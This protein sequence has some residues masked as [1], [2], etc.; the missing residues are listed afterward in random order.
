MESNCNS[1]NLFSVTA[2]NY[3]FTESAFLASSNLVAPTIIQ[4][5]VTANDRVER[6]AQIWSVDDGINSAVDLLKSDLSRNGNTSSWTQDLLTAK[7]NEL[8]IVNGKVQLDIAHSLAALGYTSVKQLT[9]GQVITDSFTYAVKDDDTGRLAWTTVT[10]SL[11]GEGMAANTVA[12]ISGTVS[13]SVSEDG[14]STNGGTVS[15]IDP[16]PG[17]AAFRAVATA[18][19]QGKYG[20][21]QFNASTGVWRYTVDSTRPEVQALWG[22]WSD[23]STSYGGNTLNESLTVT[24][25]DGTASQML[26]VTV[27]GAND[28]ALINGAGSGSD[29]FTLIDNSDSTSASGK[30]QIADADSGQSSLRLPAGAVLLPSL[31]FQGASVARYGLQMAHGSLILTPST[32]EWTYNADQAKVTALLGVETLVDSITL[33]SLDG[34]ASRKLVF[35]LQGVDNAA[36]LSGSF[37]GS[38]TEGSGRPAFPGGKIT[39]TD[40]D[41][42]QA[43]LRLPDGAI[44]LA[45]DAGTSTA[46]ASAILNSDVGTGTSP[47]PS[48]PTDLYS[49]D[50]PHGRLIISPSTGQ[51]QYI[52]DEAKLDPMHA[53]ESTQDSLV[54]TSLDG[55][56]Q[57]TLVIS[58]A[59]SDDAASI[60]GKTTGTLA[61]DGDSSVETGTL[62]VKD[63]DHD[64]SSFQDPAGGE[65]VGN[66]SFIVATPYGAFY[67]NP[68]TGDWRFEMDSGAKAV[69]ELAAD[70]N[71]QAEL[72]VTSLDGSAQETLAVTITGVNDVAQIKGETSGKVVED[73]QYQAKG[74]LDIFDPD[75]G[76]SR[77]GGHSPLQGQWGTFT[78]D[79][80][81]GDWTYTLQE[82]EALDALR[83]G[84]KRV[85]ALK[86][87]SLD[88]SAGRQITIAIYG[89]NDVASIDSAVTD[90]TVY[91]DGNSVAS[92]KL[93]LTDPDAGEDVFRAQP[94]SEAWSPAGDGTKSFITQSELGSFTFNPDTGEWHFNLDNTSRYVQE[95]GKGERTTASLTAVSKDGTATGSITVTVEGVNDTA[96]FSGE[97]TITVAADDSKPQGGTVMVSDPDQNESFFQAPSAAS[98]QGRYG[99]F[100]FETNGDKG[101]WTYTVDTRNAEV[102]AL[103]GERDGQHAQ[104]LTDALTVFSSDGKSSFDLSTTILGVDEKLQAPL[105]LGGVIE[106]MASEPLQIDLPDGFLPADPLPTKLLGKFGV[107]TVEWLD[108]GAGTPR[109]MAT[110]YF[111]PDGYAVQKL[112]EDEKVLDTVTLTDASGQS[113]VLAV[114]VLGVNDIAVIGGP[115][116]PVIVQE[117][118]SAEASGVLLVDDNDAGQANLKL[119]GMDT[120]YQPK[121]GPSF[122]LGTFDFNSMTQTWGYRLNPAQAQALGG[123]ETA[124]QTLQL[125]SADGM[126]PYSL[127]VEVR[128]AQDAATAITGNLTGQASEDGVLTV[129]GIVAVDDLDQAERQ[130]QHINGKTRYGDF[131]FNDQTGKWTYTLRNDSPEVQALGAGATGE[132]R[133]TITSIDGAVTRDIV[134]TVLGAA[135]PPRIGGTL[136]GDV[137]EDV[138]EAMKGQIA[139]KLE[140]GSSFASTFTPQTAVPGTWGQFKLLADGNWSYQ[141]DP[142]TALQ[143]LGGQDVRLDTFE[144]QTSDG[145]GKATLQIVVHG[146]NDLPTLNVLDGGLSVTLVEDGIYQQALGSLQISDA[147][148]NQSSLLPSSYGDLLANYGTFHI[149]SSPETPDKVSWTYTLNNDA[150]QSLRGGV[151]ASDS[152]DLVAMDG[153]PLGSLVINVMGQDDPFSIEGD[154]EASIVEDSDS[155]EVSGHITLRDPEGRLTGIYGPQAAYGGLSFQRTGDG[156]DWRYRLSE[157]LTVVNELNGTQGESPL[158]DAIELTA[159]DGQALGTLSIAIEGHDDPTL[160][161]PQVVPVFEDMLGT[162]RTFDE[163][164]WILGPKKMGLAYQ[165]GLTL[166]AWQAT[167]YGGRIQFEDPDSDAPFL[168]QFAVK[169]SGGYGL[170]TVE[171]DGTW[172]WESNGPHD[173]FDGEKTYTDTLKVHTASGEETTVSVVIAGANDRSEIS[174]LYVDRIQGTSVAN[175]NASGTIDVSDPDTPA[176]FIAQTATQGAWGSFS[177]D[178]SGQWTYLA[179]N[180]MQGLKADE[181]SEDAF[182]VFNADGNV[183]GVTIHISG[184]DDPTVIRTAEISRQE[185]GTAQAL[186]AFGVM[187]LEDADYQPLVGTGLIGNPSNDQVPPSFVPEALSGLY[188]RLTIDAQGAWTYT[189]DNAHD[190]FVRRHEYVDNFIVTATNGATGRLVMTLTGSDD[191]PK[192]QPLTVHVTESQAAE[193]IQLRIAMSDLQSVDP[194]GGAPLQFLQPNAADRGFIL[195]DTNNPIVTVRSGMNWGDFSLSDGYWTYTPDPSLGELGAS[196]VL[197]DTLL[198]QTTDGQSA[199]LKVVIQG[200]DSPTMLRRDN[201]ASILEGAW[202]WVKTEDGSLVPATLT[203][204]VLA[205]P[206]PDTDEP[207]LSRGNIAGK[208]G[209]FSVGSDGEWE[210]APDALKIAALAGGATASDKF[211]VDTADGQ[212][213]TVLIQIEGVESP[214]TFYENAGSVSLTEGDTAAALSSS[215]ALAF[216]DPDTSAPFVPSN[217]YGNWGTFTMLASGA[218]TYESYEAHDELAP[219]QYLKDV[220]QIQLRPDLP[221][222]DGIDKTGQ[223]VVKITGTEEAPQY[224]TTGADMLRGN[225]GANALFGGD[226]NDDLGGGEGDDLLEGGAGFDILGGGAGNDRMVGAGRKIIGADLFGL[227]SGDSFLDGLGHDIMDGSASTGKNSFNTTQATSA[228]DSTL[229]LFGTGQNVCYLGA[230][231][232]TLVI[233][234]GFVDGPH[235][236]AVGFDLALD[237]VQLDPAVFPMSTDGSPGDLYS[238]YLFSRSTSQ[239]FELHYTN[240]L[241]DKVLLDFIGLQLPEGYDFQVSNVILQ[242]AV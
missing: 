15:V 208:F 60:S 89:S 241:Y 110:Y 6:D 51:W 21:F 111:D 103:N 104:T 168:P 19:L 29:G 221:V 25:L 182:Q 11:S 211:I 139:V 125:V 32:G 230:G 95:L 127:V 38:Y 175:L 107:F 26:K 71:A 242:A 67:F 144:V 150:A 126:T 198:L 212:S 98:L 45:S 149:T 23:G 136:S 128:G 59:G 129:G 213:T 189:S 217:Q 83:E 8:R 225:K 66:G 232:D 133:L 84:D 47:G 48:K 63:P 85:D 206:D 43:A 137:T 30:L 17:Q 195:H 185:G 112:A 109:G 235:S 231:Q 193:A 183:A 49:I 197:T 228:D 134:V 147:D 152:L 236:S 69:Q 174:D 205:M 28:N 214:L 61:A 181:F 207:I 106:N 76:E 7:G 166:N 170:F 234:N 161:T 114:R 72:T 74:H 93:T 117:D 148:A 113:Q 165:S 50:L 70:T 81:T 22:A 202:N 31:E 159:A 184:V 120:T 52:P 105:M 178:A 158:I 130:F 123:R 9:Q 223:F 132:D 216:S 203:G 101:D 199:L 237:K 78:F 115:Q 200:E 82:S 155:H 20:A 226:G 219:G 142:S 58:L 172:T 102:V 75:T 79:T 204:N 118:V 44:Q 171:A 33:E 176:A 194:D 153:T 94:Q 100:T 88:A 99:W 187:T 220:F 65:A 10:F 4:L 90:L 2:D 163:E 186:S 238:P 229:L 3:S 239:G 209:R 140:P 18:S 16:D 224:G 192:L 86:V 201:G 154:L 87:E 24:S 37:T 57:Q 162:L 122:T 35:T 157:H 222:A 151:L 240:G 77:F 135:E 80:E 46:K 116:G 91:E 1:K 39:V 64:Q 218:W 190:E 146:S 54:L 34:T 141:L 36:Q 97:T 131:S 27:E 119:V 233:N 215:G 143:A 53:G 156:W 160:A 13:V 62:F 169:G 138:R 210:Y 196:A 55:S 96:Q 227:Q 179:N 12:A 121:L 188:G 40:G 124:T 180:A 173:D 68:T 41:H 56:A 73:I 167:P 108:D 92:G 164:K 191:L 5:N 14:F 145:A 177:I 42:D